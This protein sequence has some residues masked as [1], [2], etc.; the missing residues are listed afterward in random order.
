MLINQD[1]MLQLQLTNEH[2]DYLKQMYTDL[3]HR[4]SQVEMRMVQ[5]SKLWVTQ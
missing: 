3:E 2:K 5:T 4:L 1:L